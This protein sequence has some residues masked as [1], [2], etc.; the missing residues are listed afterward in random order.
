[1]LLRTALALALLVHTSTADCNPNENSNSCADPDEDTICKIN[2]P[3]DRECAPVDADK[4]TASIADIADLT[5]ANVLDQCEQKCV[6]SK[7]AGSDGDINTCRFYKADNQGVLHVCS[8]MND[9]QCQDKGSCGSHCESGDVGCPSSPYGPCKGGVEY[10]GSPF[11][12]ACFD[13]DIYSAET[14]PEGTKCWTTERC[15]GWE[16]EGVANGTHDWRRLAIPCGNTGTWAKTNNSGGSDEDYLAVLGADGA[17]APVEPTCE[18]EPVL[19]HHAVFEEDGADFLCDTEPT[20]DGGD[21]EYFQIVAP[22]T[23]ILLCDFHLAMSLDCRITSQG[24]TGCY[25][26]GAEAPVDPGNIYCWVPP[27]SDTTTTT[28]APTTTTGAP[29]TTTTGAPTTTTA[30]AVPTT[31]TAA[32][33]TTTIAAPSNPTTAPGTTTTAP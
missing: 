19:I 15:S 18:P 27:P 10:S 7:E 13:V 3:R 2:C 26:D 12:F 20:S 1:M 6:D 32:P 16:A 28:G 30:P 25:E 4:C 22:N 24:T 8:L 29:A 17:E 5:Y 31:T 23:C 11:N 33:G 21:P 9:Q 14:V